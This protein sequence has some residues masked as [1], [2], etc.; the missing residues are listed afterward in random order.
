[1]MAWQLIYS[2]RVGSHNTAWQRAAAA[3][4][5]KSIVDRIARSLSCLA[6]HPPTST[7]ALGFRGRLSA[8]VVASR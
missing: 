6:P 7:S 2:E 8:I 1:M 5:S 4:A 3:A